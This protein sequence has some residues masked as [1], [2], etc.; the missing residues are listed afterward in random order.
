MRA[1]MA[2]ARWAAAALLALALV[3]GVAGQAN[4]VV[5]ASYG[6]PRL[7]LK[8]YDWS[9]LRGERVS[10]REFLFHVEILVFLLHFFY[11]RHKLCVL[12]VLAVELP[13]SFSSVT[14]QFATD[15][16]IVSEILPSR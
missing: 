14:M 7:W 3:L 8:P 10:G 6:Q 5:V 16:D 4:P 11:R 1:P 15:I 2:A 9:Y 13:P 12:P